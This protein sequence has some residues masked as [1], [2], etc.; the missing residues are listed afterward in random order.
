MSVLHKMLRSICCATGILAPLIGYAE[1][2]RIG[3]FVVPLGTQDALN[4][5]QDSRGK[6]SRDGSPR[7]PESWPP[8]NMMELTKTYDYV[9]LGPIPARSRPLREH[10]EA[11]F[12]AADVLKA[13][14][15]NVQMD[16]V[17]STARWIHE[18]TKEYPTTNMSPGI[19]RSVPVQLDRVRK[20]STDLNR[21]ATSHQ[22]SKRGG[23]AQRLLIEL[24]RLAKLHRRDSDAWRDEVDSLTSDSPATAA[25][26]RQR[27][28]R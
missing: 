21:A 11:V 4:P 25:F 12:C 17:A 9:D 15:K 10:W 19:A 18:W 2:V 3:G 1:V 27:S 22:V 5:D 26:C 8:M 28:G 6:N 24:S 16:V 14:L 20:A 7:S 23:E 13:A